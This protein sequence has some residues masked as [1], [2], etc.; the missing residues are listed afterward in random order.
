MVR[1][2]A[3]SVATA[4][5]VAPAVRAGPFPV[6]EEPWPAPCPLPGPPAGEGLA[7]A[8]GD[9]GAGADLTAAGPPAAP[10]RSSAQAPKTSGGRRT[11]ASA[12]AGSSRV[13]ATWAAP[14]AAWV[15]ACSSAFAPASARVSSPTSP[16]GAPM[17]MNRL[18]LIPRSPR[19]CWNS[20]GR[21]RFLP[22]LSRQREGGRNGLVHARLR[23]RRDACRLRLGQATRI[24]PTISTG[25]TVSPS[26]PLARWRP[27]DTLP[28]RCIDGTPLA[29][30]HRTPETP[31]R[32]RGS[33][34]RMSTTHRQADH[35]HPPPTHGTGRE[36]A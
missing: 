15:F 2:C 6:R 27:G 14:A 21:P 28:R 29:L 3:G 13:A 1:S 18:P 10:P 9:G 12:A 31:G 11:D 16:A 34:R 23:R 25:G 4:V 33:G 32:K 35:W 30:L 24:R 20:P 26:A 19:T 36:P 8:L 22:R 7:A 17:R 5:G